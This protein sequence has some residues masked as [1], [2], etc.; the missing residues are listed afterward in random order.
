MKTNMKRLHVFC[1]FVAM[2]TGCET[3]QHISPLN[4]SFTLHAHDIISADICRVVRMVVDSANTVCMDQHSFYGITPKSN[5]EFVFEPGT[6][7]LPILLYAIDNLD[8]TVRVPVNYMRIGNDYEVV[9]SHLF[10]SDSVSL[11]D[12]LARTSKVATTSLMIQHYGNRRKELLERVRELLGGGEIL[13]I[14]ESIDN[15]TDF[16]QFCEGRGMYVNMSS[17]LKC[18]RNLLTTPIGEIMLSEEE[19]GLKG[20]SA[21]VVGNDG[22]VYAMFIGVASEYLAFVIFEDSQTYGLA[23]RDFFINV[24]YTYYEKQ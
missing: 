1:L 16:Y 4:K 20:I 12:A 22:N 10:D 17:L 18:Y 15:D 8:T 3:N 14:P 9:D 21:I 19:G 2:L 11:C 6:L 7:L 23:A 13:E 5:Y 24:M